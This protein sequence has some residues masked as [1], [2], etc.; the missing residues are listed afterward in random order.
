MGPCLAYKPLF[1]RGRTSIK[2]LRGAPGAEVGTH[3]HR[4]LE[5]TLVLKGG[6]HDVTGSYG[7]GDL[8]VSDG[9]LR[10]NPVADPGEDCINLAVTTDSL[11][12]ENW[13]QKIA[14]PLFGF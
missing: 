5:L 4:G 13:F 12:F 8:Q 2:L 14:G 11:R 3:T 1:R 10:H 6:F 9:A 7:P